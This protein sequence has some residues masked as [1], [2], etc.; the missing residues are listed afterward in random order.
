[1]EF[2]CVAL[3]LILQGSNII[4]LL[5]FEE[6]NIKIYQCLKGD[7]DQCDAECDIIF[8][9]PINLDIGL[10]KHQIIVLLLFCVKR[11]VDIVKKRRYGILNNFKE[12]SGSVTI[13]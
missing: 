2:C 13:K 12:S 4:Q 9:T 8:H 1:M 11:L 7:I 10:F 3:P 6:P 5:V